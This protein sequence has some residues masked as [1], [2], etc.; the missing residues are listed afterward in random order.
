MAI[1]YEVAAISD[2]TSPIPREPGSYEWKPVRQHFGVQ[3]FGINVMVAPEAGDWVVEEHT[4]VADSD[5]RHEELFFVSAGRATFLVDGEEVDAPAGT[6]VHVPD[7]E[8]PRG[9]RAVE[10]GTTVLAIG[11]EPGVAF[12]PSGWELKYFE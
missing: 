6:F 7:P 10:P 3:S 12:T 1:R 9:A 2:I 8:I 5:T 4:E 11:A